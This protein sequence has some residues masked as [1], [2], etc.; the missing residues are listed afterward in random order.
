MKL[1]YNNPFIALKHKNFRYYW[2]GMCISVIG[3][4]MQNIAQPWLA[5]KLTNSPLLLSF[6]G[7][8]QFT[9]VLLFS[10]F[11][12]VIIDK[13]PKKNI[14]IFTQ[15]TSLVITFILAILDWTGC[16]RY[17]HILVM[18]TLL[19]L[20]NTLDMPTR[21]AFVIEMVGR[22]DVKNAVAL[23]SSAFNLARIIG[24]AA[25]GIIMGYWGTAACF[26]INSISF[27]AV[28]ISLL[29][30]KCKGVD[31]KREESRNVFA[32][33]KDG[34]KYIYDNGILFN[35]ILVMTVVGTFGMNLSV[36]VPVFAKEILKQQEAGFGF[37]MSLMG[38]GSFIGAMLVATTS[39]FKSQRFNKFML[40]AVPLILA[41]FLILTGV[42]QSFALTGVGLVMTGL[43]FVA[44]SATANSTMQLKS[45][46]EYRGRAMSVFSLAFAGTTPIGNFFAG[47][48]TEHF[49]ANVGFLACG[50]AII[51]FL[52][53]IYIY[54]EAKKSYIKEN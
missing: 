12:G 31:I 44:Y 52:V 50:V 4:W 25:A 29:F 35:T 18:A 16:I 21:Q 22:E 47:I 45:T 20:V 19:G 17:W 1:E 10:L 48:I 14:L 40:Y 7:I 3:V 54:K 6:V 30:I 49:G 43:S 34:L 9:P 36:L 53:A 13:F 41:V 42:T 27:A 37:L 39:N 26:F 51:L 24:P 2:I 8:L 32:N 15:S 38:V 11:A 23:N 5:Y 46:D 33:I 28:V